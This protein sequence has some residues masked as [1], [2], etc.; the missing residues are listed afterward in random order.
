MAIERKTDFLG[1]EYYEGDVGDQH[2]IAEPKTDIFGREFIQVH[3]HDRSASHEQLGVRVIAAFILIAL[4]LVGA[5]LPIL[6]WWVIMKDPS[7]AFN[8]ASLVAALCTAHLVLRRPLPF[9]EAFKTSFGWFFLLLT[10]A[11]LVL[12]FVIEEKTLAMDFSI[13]NLLGL[14]LVTFLAAVAPALL[15]SIASSFVLRF[16]NRPEKNKGGR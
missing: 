5:A 4:A 10:P 3:T 8:G 12:S 11:L 13:S 1:D 2:V 6:L 14:I 16:K 15:I 9:K 7:P